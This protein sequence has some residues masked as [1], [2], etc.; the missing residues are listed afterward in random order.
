MAQAQPKKKNYWCWFI[1]IAACLASMCGIGLVSNSYGIFFPSIS[2]DLGTPL[3]AQS[4]MATIAAW[5]TTCFYWIGAKIMNT[6]N[7]RLLCFISGLLVAVALFGYSVST[8]LWHFY[9]F[10]AL[11]GAMFAFAGLN[12]VP[13]LINN[14]F[15]KYRNTVT[16]LA[17]M[18]TAV[19]GAVGNPLLASIIVSDGW[20]AA[21]RV[22]G[23]IALSYPI[24][25][26]IFVRGKPAEMGLQP[27]GLDEMEE[28][29]SIKGQ[30]EIKEWPGVPFK[31]GIKTPAMW[32]LFGFAV[33]N[34]L[35]TGYNQ[36]WAN[37][38]LTYGFDLVTAS[39]LTTAAMVGS[40]VFKVI[41]GFLNDKIGIGITTTIYSAAGIVGMI[42]CLTVGHKSFGALIVACVLFGMSVA[43][44]TLQCPQS[45]REMFGMRAF[46]AFYPFGMM[47]MGLGTGLTYSLNSKFLADTGSYDFSQKFNIICIGIALICMAVAFAGKKKMHEKY[48]REVG[49]E[50]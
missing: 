18:M 24:W 40:A 38:G 32:L 27:I 37:T 34:G 10:A 46:A 9:C 33:F 29:K 35:S 26:I 20:R 17:Y 45:Y 31:Y 5:T 50:I 12:I 6:M 49:E 3:T 16:G 44:T 42:M 8:Q 19:M 13:L 41:A 4:L 23:C 22:A 43:L 30:V 1:F 21:Y 47:G 28:M 25:C 11:C 48:W 39:T 2:A 15:I 7:T 14:W 36:H